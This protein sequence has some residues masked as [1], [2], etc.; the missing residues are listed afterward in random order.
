MASTGKQ[1]DV[2][3]KLLHHG[4]HPFPQHEVEEDADESDDDFGWENLGGA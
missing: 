4:Q 2:L 1:E 3:L